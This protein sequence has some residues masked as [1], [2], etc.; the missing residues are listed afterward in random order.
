MHQVV[1][2]LTFSF[3]SHGIHI[4]GEATRNK[5][6]IVVRLLR[7]MQRFSPKKLCIQRSSSISRNMHLLTLNDIESVYKI[8]FEYI[9]EDYF[10]GFEEFLQVDYE[11][12]FTF[13]GHNPKITNEDIYLIF[14]SLEVDSIMPSLINQEG[15]DLILVEDFRQ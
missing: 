5:K 10:V 7:K 9:Y 1:K 8:L 14:D 12:D 13:L 2:K 11:F 3:Y 15:D 6:M 4:S